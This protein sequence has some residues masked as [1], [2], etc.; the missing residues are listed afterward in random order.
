MLALL[1]WLRSRQ[2]PKQ[3]KRRKAQQ[4]PRIVFS[5]LKL[6]SYPFKKAEIDIISEYGICKIY[7]EKT[8]R[9]K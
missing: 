1:L 2:E 6:P 3:P 8:S 7:T 4:Q 5:N 9:P